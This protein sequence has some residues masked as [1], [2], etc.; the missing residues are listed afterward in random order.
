MERTVSN[1]REWSD[2]HRETQI[3]IETHKVCG[4]HVVDER[5]ALCPYHRGME[6][7]IDLI[8]DSLQYEQDE[9]VPV[10]PRLTDLVGGGA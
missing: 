5:W 9:P 1:F 3:S 8:L 7:G 6:D 10:N 2:L 4:C